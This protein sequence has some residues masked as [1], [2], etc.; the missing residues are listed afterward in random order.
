MESEI[1]LGL[2]YQHSFQSFSPNFRSTHYGISSQKG[3]HCHAKLQFLLWIKT[4]L[5]PCIV[6]HWVEGKMYLLLC[7]FGLSFRIMSLA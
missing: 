6:I 2:H 7:L 3:A 4:F 5:C 1:S